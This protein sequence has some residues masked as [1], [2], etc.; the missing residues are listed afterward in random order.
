MN[1]HLIWVIGLIIIT[2]IW[3]ATILWVNYHTFNF[4]F[5]MDD[6]TLQAVKSIN[7][8]VIK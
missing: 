1:K 8:S 2:L 7:W 4:S 5:T 3:C 6:N